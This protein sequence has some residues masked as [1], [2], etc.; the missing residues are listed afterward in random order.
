MCSAVVSHRVCV[1]WPKTKRKGR[2]KV[3][4]KTKRRSLSSEY[5][6][7][8]CQW[9]RQTG[10]MSAK[11]AALSPGFQQTFQSKVHELFTSFQ[12]EFTLQ[13]LRARFSKLF[14]YSALFHRMMRVYM[15]SFHR[16][17]IALSFN[18]YNLYVFT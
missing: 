17:N 4:D 11:F 13:S 3:K 1:T 16:S 5:L 12:D 15:L 10:M 14:T 9:I 2:P 18:N 7:A 6:P 8:C